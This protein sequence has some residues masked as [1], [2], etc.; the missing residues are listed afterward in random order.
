[1]RQFVCL[2]ETFTVYL[3]HFPCIWW[4]HIIGVKQWRWK[5]SCFIRRLFVWWVLYIYIEREICENSLPSEMSDMCP[6]FLACTGVKGLKLLATQLCI[7]KFHEFVE[8]KNKETSTY[9][10]L[11]FCE[12]N[13]PMTNGPVMWKTFPIFHIMTSSCLDMR[14]FTSLHSSCSYTYGSHQI[15]MLP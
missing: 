4:Y 14:L 7:Q 10:L 1:M 8:D 11:A 15:F 9:T 5:L 12:G 3:K 2:N 6:K 13:P